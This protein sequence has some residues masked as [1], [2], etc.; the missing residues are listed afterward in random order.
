MTLKSY[1]P[2]LKAGE[3]PQSIENASTSRMRLHLLQH[4]V[5]MGVASCEEQPP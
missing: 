3:R 5:Q 2:L 1:A 4:L